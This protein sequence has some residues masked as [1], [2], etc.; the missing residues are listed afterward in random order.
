MNYNKIE[1]YHYFQ[2]LL[3][4]W[5]LITFIIAMTGITLAAPYSGDATWD[6]FD[7]IIISILV[8]LSS[9]W[10]VGTLYLFI[11][12]KRSYKNL[13]IAIVMLLFSSSWFY[14]GYILIRDGN[15]PA[16]W[17]QNL[18]ISPAFFIAAGMFWNLEYMPGLGAKFSFQ[19]DGWYHRQISANFKKLFWIALPFG[20]F[21]LYAV[22]WF[23]WEFFFPE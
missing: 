20:L 3:I 22:F 16:T 17:L 15:Y 5:K 2:F 19:L 11:T 1:L 7:S 12:K 9:P 21:T 8:Y 10:A 13:F 6:Y 4:P 23:V 18:I 14:D